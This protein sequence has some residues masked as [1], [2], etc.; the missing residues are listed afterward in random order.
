MSLSTP[1]PSAERSCRRQLDV[2]WP[3]AALAGTAMIAKIEAML[4]SFR[5]GLTSANI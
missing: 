5:C 2:V 1:G 4:R 3:R